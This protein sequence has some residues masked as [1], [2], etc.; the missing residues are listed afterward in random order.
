[1]PFEAGV[2]LVD[3]L[4]GPDMVERQNAARGGPESMTRLHGSVSGVSQIVGAF[5]W[6]EG[7][8]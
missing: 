7:V 1:M 6:G 2:L 3:Q 5:D 8:E 4:K